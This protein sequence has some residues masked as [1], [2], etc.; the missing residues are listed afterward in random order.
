MTSL[1]SASSPKA[2]PNVTPLIDVLLVLLIIFMV[3]MPPLSAGLDASIP[4]IPTQE[5]KPSNN[6]IVVTVLSD[7]TVMLNQERLSL[8]DLD[9]RLRLLFKMAGNHALFIRG[10]RR[11][12]FEQIAQVIDIARGAGLT[13]IGLMTE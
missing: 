2:E 1:G 3:I 9:A 10:D 13:R 5:A 11:L 8:V 4:Q 7:Q 12:D 6:D